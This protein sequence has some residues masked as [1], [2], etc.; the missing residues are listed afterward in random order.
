MEICEPAQAR[1][2][3]LG[4]VERDVGGGPRAAH[5]SRHGARKRVDIGFQWG[6]VLFVIGGVV[7][8]DDHHRHVRPARVVQIGQAVAQSGAQM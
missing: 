6:V 8:D 7:A 5:P 3:R 4:G 2:D 1:G